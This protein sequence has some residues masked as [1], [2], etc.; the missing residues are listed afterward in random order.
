MRPN[1]TGAAAS[2]CQDPSV[3]LLDN[4]VW[5]ALSGPQ[6]TVAEARPY[7]ARYQPDVAMFAAVPDEPTDAS[8]SDLRELVGPGG[9]AL[10]FV[11]PPNMP[12]GWEELFGVHAFQMVATAV[13]PEPYPDAQPLG[14]DN[15][16]EMLALVDRTN[17]GPFETRTIELGEYIG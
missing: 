11:R 17:P 15:V 16:H 6:K 14:P 9:I 1:A 12:D 2:A 4:P 13:D 8:W 7:A 3:D 10:L 5:H